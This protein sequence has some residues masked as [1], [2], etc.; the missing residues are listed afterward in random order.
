MCIIFQKW[1]THTKNDTVLK[2]DSHAGYRLA[3]FMMSPWW[4][5]H[6]DVPKL[7]GC[8][9]LFQRLEVQ[10]NLLN[11]S[12]LQSVHI[13]VN[14]IWATVS[15]SSKLPRYE[16]AHPRSSFQSCRTP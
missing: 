5:S 10:L 1:C 14:S 9:H 7:C 4:I 3:V 2:V 15:C 13:D 16:V 8:Q 12:L 11:L 6:M